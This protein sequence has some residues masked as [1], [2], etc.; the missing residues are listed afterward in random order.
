MTT[1]TRIPLPAGAKRAD[2]WEVQRD[3][4]VT[5]VF[6][7][8]LRDRDRWCI[9]I[10]GEQDYSGAVIS[11]D[12]FVD[13]D[14]YEDVLDAADLRQLAADCL[15]TADELELGVVTP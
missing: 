2:D 4:S 6:R 12:A 10:I 5:R 15:A 11:R 8:A 14:I 13:M 3:G 9:G 7:G 1:A